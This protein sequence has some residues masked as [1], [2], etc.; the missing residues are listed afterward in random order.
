MKQYLLFIYFFNLLI[1]IQSSQKWLP[2][3]NGYSDYA[4]IFWKAISSLR[5]SGNKEYRVHTLG[6]S[7]LPA[8]TGNSQNDANNG[9]A[10][11]DGVAI[12][13]IAIKGA[14]YKVHILGGSWLSEVSQYNINDLNYGMAGIIGKKIDAIMIKDRT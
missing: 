3:V 10:G 8:V 7:W 5:V 14:T 1:L 6:G 12:D 9:Y 4:G 13:G 11:I 2:E